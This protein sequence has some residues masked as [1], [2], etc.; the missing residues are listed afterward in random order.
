M[1]RTLLAAAAVA[2]LALPVASFAAEN[3]NDQPGTST[4]AKPE[5][6]KQSPGTVG[7]M[8]HDPEGSSFTASK[9]TQK[10]MHLKSNK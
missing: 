6:A 4:A 10:K 8:N 5:G 9:K 2:C 7:A 1:T 3:P